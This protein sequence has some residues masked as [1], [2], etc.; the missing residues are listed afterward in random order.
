MTTYPNPLYSLDKEDLFR[1]GEEEYIHL[2]S[3]PYRSI[4]ETDK[5]CFNLIE[6]VHESILSNT[7]V[8]AKLLSNIKD[9]EI[10]E[11][12]Y[13]CLLHYYSKDKLRQSIIRYIK[14]PSGPQTRNI[15]FQN[16]DHILLRSQN[17]HEE[18]AQMVL[19]YFKKL[20]CTGQINNNAFI[21]KSEWTSAILDN[22]S[23]T[24]RAVLY[25]SMFHI[26]MKFL[27]NPKFEGLKN[28]L[29]LGSNQ[30]KLVARTG[31]LDPKWHDLNKFDFSDT[32]K[33]KM[34][35]FFTTNDLVMFSQHAIKT[36]DVVNANLY[37]EL[38]VSKFESSVTLEDAMHKPLQKILNVMLSHSM[39][40]K[41]ARE[42]IKF[43]KYML[44]SG[45][46]ITPS[47]LL[48]ILSRLR[49]DRFSDEALF[50]INHLHTEKLEPAQKDIL[51]GEIMKVINNKFTEHPEVAVGYFAAIFDKDDPLQLLKDLRIL[52][53]IY[54]PSK[55]ISSI[56]SADIHKDLTRIELSHSVLHSMYLILFRNLAPELRSNPQ[57]I[58]QMY[59]AYTSKIVQAQQEKDIASIFHPENIDD[60]VLTLF[61]E[62]L[63]RV[64]PYS[65][66]DML[67][68]TD[69]VRFKVAKEITENFF[70]LVELNRPKRTVYLF[71]LLISSSLL[72]HG[73]HT[74][75][76]RMLKQSREAGLPLS[77]NQLY[78]F[79]MY[80]YSR[81]QYE[82]AEQ[83][84]AILTRDGVKA[85][86]VAADELIKI[87]KE[88]NWSVKGTAYRRLGNLK[89]RR[90]RK[91]LA[92]L[93][94]DPILIISK[95]N[96]LTTQGDTNLLEELGS[97][98]HTRS[99]N[100]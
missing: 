35:A 54:G 57:L 93:A 32:H 83:W 68:V 3:I 40:F 12:I 92:D 87:A 1:L 15:V 59:Q 95:S 53:L 18:A 80:H 81:A 41:G 20:A 45:L 82:L 61:I 85:K 17:S 24:Q 31:I 73:D 67:L 33:Q 71:D 6:I 44:D 29:L 78:P 77:F 22:I 55:E 47:T 36:K 10:R 90:A 84:Y 13:E 39:M 9:A 86:S 48:L 62:H 94:K 28:A 14:D 38:L 76:A 49:A 8:V 50:V 79:I 2:L 27:D 7:A 69:D 89:N 26:N 58:E 96:T 11:V 72:T 60:S 37:L 75:A 34:V 52:D 21:L 25:A 16:I 56:R 46:K 63:L 98:L 91:E 30:E 23:D 4:S 66:T 100:T 42:C 64:D 97:L 43:L 74:F 99:Q 51:V 5:F 88:L 65:K 19:S 70:A